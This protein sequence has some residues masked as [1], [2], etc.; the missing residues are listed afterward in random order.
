ML[1]SGMRT[2]LNLDGKLV[3]IARH[4]AQFAIESLE[5]KP[6]GKLRNGVSLFVPRS[7]TRK[8]RL[9]LVSQ[10]RDDS[11]APPLARKQAATS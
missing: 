7:G 5:P 11:F 2:T 3:Q 6:P 8:P 4:L 1:Q 10:L 9:K